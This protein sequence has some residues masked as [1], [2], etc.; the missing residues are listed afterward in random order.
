MQNK[1]NASLYTV[2][3]QRRVNSRKLQ[4]GI[5]MISRMKT[6]LFQ[7][8]GHCWVSQICWHIE[9]SSSWN[10]CLNRWVDN[11]SGFNTCPCWPQPYLM[12]SNT[13]YTFFFCYLR[14][15]KFADSP[16]LLTVLL[17]SFLALFPLFCFPRWSPFSEAYLWI[18]L[19]LPSPPRI[20]FLIKALIFTFI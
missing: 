7:S 15:H 10:L 16:S 12:L 11:S 5:G 3:L 9:C 13:F 19:L 20:L 4:H 6:D 18:L 1:T 17:S 8:C 2:R 14:A